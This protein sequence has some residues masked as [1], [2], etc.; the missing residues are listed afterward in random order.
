MIPRNAFGELWDLSAPEHRSSSVRSECLMA[1]LIIFAQ[2]SPPLCPKSLFKSTKSVKTFARSGALVWE[3]ASVNQ[4]RR[5]NFGEF[6]F[7]FLTH[8][9]Y[10]KQ[11]EHRSACR[12][13]TV[14]SSTLM[15]HRYD[16]RMDRIQTT[17]IHRHFMAAPWI[18]Q[19]FMP[20]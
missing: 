19:W 17:L 14:R 1:I 15:N 3:L 2:L 12:A 20:L 9:Q 8:F 4:P 7:Q 5:I 16:T 13:I 11:K 18:L 10:E 6:P